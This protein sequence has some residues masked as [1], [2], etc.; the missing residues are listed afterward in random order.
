MAKSRGKSGKMMTKW[1]RMC[2]L[3]LKDLINFSTNA[4]L[5][6]LQGGNNNLRR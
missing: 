5:S 1:K 6:I 4:R 2:A 3:L